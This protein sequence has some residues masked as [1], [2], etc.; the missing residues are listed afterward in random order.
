MKWLLIVVNSP[1]HIRL[2]L[3]KHDYK[4]IILNFY[5]KILDY[6][7][8][9]NINNKYSFYQDPILLCNLILLAFDFG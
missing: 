5:K 3:K 9:T 2:S 6:L 8:F 4:K 1:M 7:K